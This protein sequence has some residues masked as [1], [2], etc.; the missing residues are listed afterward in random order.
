MLGQ[1]PVEFDISSMDTFSIDFYHKMN[2]MET[3][4]NGGG[5]NYYGIARLSNGSNILNWFVYDV[6]YQLL[7]TNNNHRIINGMEL[8]AYPQVLKMETHC[9][10]PR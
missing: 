2:V 3:S 8:Q 1:P 9:Y 5:T 7:I 10:Q 4:A 6:N